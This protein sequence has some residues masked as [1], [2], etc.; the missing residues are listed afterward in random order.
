MDAHDAIIDCVSLVGVD[1]ERC[2][3][4]YGF[5]SSVFVGSDP[6]RNGASADRGPWD[7][8]GRRRGMVSPESVVCSSLRNSLLS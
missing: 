7:G 1:I 4:V 6:S 5:I 2:C 8:L 3:W